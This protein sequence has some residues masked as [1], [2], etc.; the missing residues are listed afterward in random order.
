MNVKD[1]LNMGLNEFNKL[2]AD[3]LR[4]VTNSLVSAAN[5]RVRRFEAAGEKSPALSQVENEGR[6]STA[7]KSLNELRQEFAR[8]RRFMTAETGN[9]RGARKVRNK[10]VNNLSRAGV[11]ISQDQYNNFFEAYEKLKQK[12]PAVAESKFKY[13]AM[14]EIS[15]RIDDE[16]DPEEVAEA[17][18]RDFN[19]IYENAENEEQE[20]ANISDF[21]ETDEDL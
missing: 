4:K 2:K 17:L 5:K 13:L 21:F 20:Y 1:I 8:A 15:N 16:M 14:R 10:V 3:A 19:S 12:D 11:N 18:A 7:N 9:L 6:F